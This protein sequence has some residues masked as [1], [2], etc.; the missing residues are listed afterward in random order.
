MR[1]SNAPSRNSNV[2]SFS[3]KNRFYIEPSKAPEEIK[4]IN[5]S[6]H[7]KETDLNTKRPNPRNH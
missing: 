2:Q 1:Q 4:R 7:A 3:F 6:V 5:D